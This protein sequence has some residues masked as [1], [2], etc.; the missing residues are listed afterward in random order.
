MSAV[1][2]GTVLSGIVIN[3][4]PVLT[5]SQFNYIPRSVSKGESASCNL[6]YK[7]IA[8]GEEVVSLHPCNHKYHEKCAFDW[9][10]QKSTHCPECGED[11]IKV[12]GLPEPAFY[13]QQRQ[14]GNAGAATYAM[15]DPNHHNANLNGENY[16][17][18]PNQ[19]H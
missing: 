5:F 2:Q 11:M 13:N 4:H 15:P 18:A 9:F 10:T 14:A 1:P 6:C 17:A 19:A 16:P 7:N 3:P 8:K 12:M